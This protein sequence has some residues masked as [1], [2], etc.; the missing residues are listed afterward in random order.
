M[1][2]RRIKEVLGAEPSKLTWQ[3]L[4]SLIANGIEETDEIEFKEAHYDNINGKQELA[5]DIAAF[6]NSSGGI[7]LI[8]IEEERSSG[9]AISIKP[10]SIGQQMSLKYR[11]IIANGI[12][13]HVSIDIYMVES[14]DEASLGVMVIVVPP[15]QMAPYSIL[16]DGGLRF[17]FRN[18]NHVIYWREHQVSD[19]YRR[20]FASGE[21]LNSLIKKRESDF[22][23][24]LDPSD[25]WLVMTLVPDYSQIQAMS[26]SR[27]EELKSSLLRHDATLPGVGY[28]FDRV[29]GG[30][31]RVRGEISGS[32]GQTLSK[33]SAVELHTDGSGCYALQLNK[34]DLSNLRYEYPADALILPDES[35]ALALLGGLLWLGGHIGNCASQ[36][37]ANFRVRIWPAEPSLLA[38]LGHVRDYL[39]NPGSYNEP[40]RYMGPVEIS[41]PISQVIE[42]GT[43]MIVAAE[44]IGREVAQSIGTIEIPQFADDG[45][46]RQ[47]YWSTSLWPKIKQWCDANGI[48]FSDETLS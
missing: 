24:T 7:L 46:V 22:L 2:A 3:N 47:K 21:D 20:R 43:E 4:E 19:G 40:V 5:K 32:V 17:P 16:V 37:M 31:R 29:R 34:I 25:S 48:D 41:L 28:V 30:H 36:G 45:R 42:P 1:P 44:A 26:R 9:K 8:G 27:F 6:A 23:L 14:P 18:G 38:G 11:Q 12:S 13:P 33:D 39:A 35:I 15:S 10:V